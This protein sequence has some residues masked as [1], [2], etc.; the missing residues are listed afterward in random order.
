MSKIVNNELDTQWYKK[1]QIVHGIFTILAGIFIIIVVIFNK[2]V[3]ANILTRNDNTLLYVAIAATLLFPIIS[4]YVFYRRIE[5]INL[6]E[7]VRFRFG[8]YLT[9]SVLR[10]LWITGAGIL[11]IMVW[12]FTAT[13]LIAGCLGLLF[14][15]MLLIR[16][17]KLKVIRT[18]RLKPI[19]A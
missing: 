16:P 3:G 4:N 15:V 12:F 2:Q 10:Y 17:V 7:P 11:D 6:D 5:Q 8:N 13:I 14:L 19:Q 1:L 18:L 9:A